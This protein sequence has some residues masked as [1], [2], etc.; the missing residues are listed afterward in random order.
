MQAGLDSQAL[1]GLV[2]STSNVAHHHHQKSH[3]WGSS[4]LAS[5]VDM[6]DWSLFSAAAALWM[7][8]LGAWMRLV[9]FQRV[10]AV[11]GGAGPQVSH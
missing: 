6:T 3:F 4:P 9:S 7:K 10:V 11:C 2:I 1:F 8:Q 5:L